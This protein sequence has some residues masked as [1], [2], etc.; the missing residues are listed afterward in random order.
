MQNWTQYIFVAI[1]IG[2]IIYRRTKKTIG[3]QKL[4]RNRLMFRTIMFGI[5]G[6]VI[7]GLGFIHPIFFVADAVGLVGGIALGLIAIR[8]TRFEKR[9]DIWFYRTHLW[10]EITVLVLFLGRIA[11]RLLFIVSASS[12]NAMNPAD[13]SQ[14]SKDPLTAGIFFV[15]VS[16]Y[17]LYF[18][19]LLK[20][21]GKLDTRE[22]AGPVVPGE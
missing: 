11:Y 15:I 10:V 2:F 16:F 17:L 3:F 1:L 9:E 19:Y 6:L 14:I 8:H 22:G 12:P 13:P 21:E 5:L 18:V 20:E 7:L 4:S